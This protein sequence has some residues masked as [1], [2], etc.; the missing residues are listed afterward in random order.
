M[1]AST[2]PESVNAVVE[3]AGAGRAVSAVAQ[4]VVSVL[5]HGEEV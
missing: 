4:G 5:G 3:R 2:I 1:T